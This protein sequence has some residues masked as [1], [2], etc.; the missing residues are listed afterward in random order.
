MDIPILDTLGVPAMIG[1]S[2]QA[3][4][5]TGIGLDGDERMMGG[6][7]KSTFFIAFNSLSN[8]RE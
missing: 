8:F 4:K 1:E 7:G 3:N 5:R 2:C 6:K